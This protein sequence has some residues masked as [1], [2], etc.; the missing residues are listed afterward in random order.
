MRIGFGALFGSVD[1]G[2]VWRAAGTLALVIVTADEFLDPWA[3]LFTPAP[4]V[5]HTIMTDALL[6]MVHAHAVWQVGGKLVC[7]AGLAHA[8]NVIALALDGQKGGFGDG[9]IRRT[10]NLFI[11]LSR[12]RAPDVWISLYEPWSR[13]ARHFEKK[14][15]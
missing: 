10:C 8:C 4:P 13:C 7:G 12:S 3:D 9:G 14:N 1:M 11:L 6:N 2:N 5:K 15:Q